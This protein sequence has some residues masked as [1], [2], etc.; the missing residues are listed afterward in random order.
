MDELTQALDAFGPW[1]WA[2][3]GANLTA[4]ALGIFALRC[5][6]GMPGVIP[7]HPVSAMNAA[8]GV[9]TS[10]M[11]FGLVFGLVLAAAAQAFSSH[12]GIAQAHVFT[13]AFIGQSAAALTMIAMGAMVPESLRWAPDVSADEPGESPLRRAARAFTFPR[14]LLV[15]LALFALGLAL[16]ALWK[17]LHVGWTQLFRHGLLGEPPADVPQ[18]IVDSVL[19]TDVDTWRFGTIILAVTIGAPVMEELAF[20]GMLYPGLRRLLTGASERHARWIAVA[21]TGLIFSAAHG[22]PSAAL[23]LFGFGA[24]MCLV[25]D[26]Y[27]LLTCMAAH[28]CF[29][30]WNLAWLKLAPAA[31]TL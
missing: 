19:K 31:S 18:D 21:L 7:P 25:R 13:A 15:L 3:V 26:R 24:F 12:F 28:A 2:C 10:V 17:G 4:A 1:D 9:V 6:R 23:P 30:G 22:S 11:S 27:G 5:W 16:T 8:L 14:L 20:R 29:N